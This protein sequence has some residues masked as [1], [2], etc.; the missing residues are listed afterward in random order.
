MPGNQIRLDHQLF[1]ALFDQARCFGILAR[2]LGVLFLAVTVPSEILIVISAEVMARKMLVCANHIGHKPGETLTIDLNRD[3]SEFVLLDARL[4]TEDLAGAVEEIDRIMAARDGIDPRTSERLRVP[5]ELSESLFRRSVRA[6]F[7][8][9]YSRMPIPKADPRLAELL[10]LQFDRPGDLAIFTNCFGEVDLCLRG[11]LDEFERRNAVMAKL[12]GK[13]GASCE[14]DFEKMDPAKKAR[15][16]QEFA[17]E[18][19][20]KPD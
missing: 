15:Y 7:P 1:E 11:T 18:F 2:E 17:R 4:A 9:R 10:R 19:A 13:Y 5:Y 14:D 8:E 12:A 3:G 6:V 16:D 20:R